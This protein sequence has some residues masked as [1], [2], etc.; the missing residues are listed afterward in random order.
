MRKGQSV[1][2]GVTG[3]YVCLLL[4]KLVSLAQSVDVSSLLQNQNSAQNSCENGMQVFR[5][6]QELNLG[7]LEAA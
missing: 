6:S 7:Q 1:K 3:S 2:H 5:P 4:K